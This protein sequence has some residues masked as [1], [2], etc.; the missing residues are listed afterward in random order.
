M[1]AFSAA[2]TGDSGTL[3]FLK[4]VNSVSELYAVD[5]ATGVSCPSALTP[6]ARR[7]PGRRPPRWVCRK[8]PAVGGHPAGLT[9]KSAARLPAV[10]RAA[11]LPAP[12]ARGGSALARHFPHPPR[13][14]APP[15]P[16][17]T[18]RRWCAG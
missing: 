18:R 1:A 14:P 9:D 10:L 5:V 6:R 13:I 7:M 8:R 17:H 2:F 15:P 3:G 16:S 4:P 12:L 11:A